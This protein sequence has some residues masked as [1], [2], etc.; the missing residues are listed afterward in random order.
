M[1]TCCSSSKA[2]GSP[3]T[4]AWRKSCWKA[5]ALAACGKTEQACRLAGR[6]CVALRRTDPAMARRFD[7]LLHRMA[8]L[9]DPCAIDMSGRIYRRHRHVV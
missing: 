1:V 3:W 4:V 2:G 7:V 8:R 6:A 5:A 9:A